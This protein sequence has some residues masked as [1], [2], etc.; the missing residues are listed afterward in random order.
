MQQVFKSM[1]AYYGNIYIH[2]YTMFS[3]CVKPKQVGREV[4]IDFNKLGTPFS[5]T[6][7]KTRIPIDEPS[8]KDIASFVRKK[9][10]VD[11]S[12]YLA[13]IDP[14]LGIIMCYREFNNAIIPTRGP[15]MIRISVTKYNTRKLQ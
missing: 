11:S 10:F 12:I 15:I 3:C 7:L 9:G 5:T 4:W 14:V 13:E 2:T 8:L 1:M 6:P